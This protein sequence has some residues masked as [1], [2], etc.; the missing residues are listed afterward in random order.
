MIFTSIKLQP[1]EE[2]R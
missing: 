1:Q 2:L